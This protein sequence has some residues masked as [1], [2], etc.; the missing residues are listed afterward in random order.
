[1]T[2]ALDGPVI[3]TAIS[4]DLA[5]AVAQVTDETNSAAI[6]STVRRTWPPRLPG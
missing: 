5:A 3:V 1:V 2:D 6:V 4:V